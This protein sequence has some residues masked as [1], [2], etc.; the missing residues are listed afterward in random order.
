MTALTDTVMLSKVLKSLCT[1]QVRCS[2]RINFLKVAQS[3]FKIRQCL[4]NLLKIHELK[5]HYCDKFKT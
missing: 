1:T 2:I 5:F 4:S 3:L